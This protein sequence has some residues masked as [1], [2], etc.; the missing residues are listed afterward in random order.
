MQ[1]VK[2]L[3]IHNILY[4]L[5]DP[6]YGLEHLAKFVNIYII[7][8]SNFKGISISKLIERIELISS[9][10]IYEAVGE[11]FNKQPSLVAFGQRVNLIPTASDISIF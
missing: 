2:K 9:N 3:L 11:L 10:H 5:E 6:N 1:F 4:G 8:Y 7:K